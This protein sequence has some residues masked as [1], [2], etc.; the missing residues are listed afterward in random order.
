M[1]VKRCKSLSPEPS[2][3]TNTK[4][5]K[6]DEDDEENGRSIK[7]S[8]LHLSDDVLLMIIKFLD[9][10]DILNLSR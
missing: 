7:P 1:K 8:L 3:S 9:P 10:F 4:R 6:R 5:A 2:S